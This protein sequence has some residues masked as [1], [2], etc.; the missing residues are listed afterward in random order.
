MAKSEKKI[1]EFEEEMVSN[2]NLCKSRAEVIKN[3][4]TDIADDCYFSTP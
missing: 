2:A 3:R 4:L 1:K